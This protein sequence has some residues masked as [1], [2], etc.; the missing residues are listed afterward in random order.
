MVLTDYQKVPLQDAFKKAMLGDKERAADDT[1]YLL[2]GGYNPL[3]VQITH[4]LNNKAGLAWTSYSHTAVPIGTS[5]MGGGE[6]S[7][8]GYYENTD[9]AKKIME[10]MGVDYTLQM[11]QN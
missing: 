1:T 9:G 3:T 2:Y 10:F 8:N 6:D 4:I 7:F 5:A 11:A